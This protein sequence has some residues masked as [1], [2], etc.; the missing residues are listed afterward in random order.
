M[1]RLEALRVRK[2]LSSSSSDHR[3]CSRRQ[4][5]LL[6]TWDS[7]RQAHMAILHMQAIRRPDTPCRLP[8]MA[9][10]R[11]I[12]ACRDMACRRD[13]LA[14]NQAKC[15]AKCQGTACRQALL[16][17]LV[18]LPARPPPL[19]LRG[20]STTPATVQSTTTTR[21]Q[22]KANG[23]SRLECKDETLACCRYAGYLF[24]TGHGNFFVREFSHRDAR[25]TQPT[26]LGGTHGPSMAP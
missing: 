17:L 14:C 12:L 24:T 8:H 4:A 2:P 13:I 25:E 9:P 10:C 22:V 5:V 7:L 26:L 11:D 21:K 19:P 1:G 20:R 23:K 3:E 6:G 16:A 18:P 15:Q